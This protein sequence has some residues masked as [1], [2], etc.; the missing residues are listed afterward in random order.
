MSED[1]PIALRRLYR[2]TVEALPPVTRTVFL[3][4]RADEL[5]T[6]DVAERLGLSHEAIADHLA[7]ALITLDRALRDA[8]H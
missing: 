7:H 8:G 2:S 4:H 5:S 3:L 6:A 1:P